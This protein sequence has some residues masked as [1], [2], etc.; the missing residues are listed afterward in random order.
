MKRAAAA[1]A[2]SASAIITVVFVLPLFSAG[3]CSVSS[4]GISFNG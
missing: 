3:G 2:E 4:V 1:S